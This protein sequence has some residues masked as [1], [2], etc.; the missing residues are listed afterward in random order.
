MVF[1]PAGTLEQEATSVWQKLPPSAFEDHPV[2]RCDRFLSHL[3][4]VRPDNRSLIDDAVQRIS[5]KLQHF[6]S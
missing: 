2:T 4:E 1:A 5:P 3:P 6:G